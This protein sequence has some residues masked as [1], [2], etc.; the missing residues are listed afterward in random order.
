MSGGRGQCSHIEA[1]DSI[2]MSRGR[3]QH[4]QVRVSLQVKDVSMVNVSFEISLK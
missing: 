4:G 3:G 2:G 1:E